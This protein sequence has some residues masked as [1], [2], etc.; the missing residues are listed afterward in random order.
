MLNPRQSKFL[1]G[2]RPWLGPPLFP[3]H[4]IDRVK[5]GWEWLLRTTKGQPVKDLKGRLTKGNQ[6]RSAVEEIL[7]ARGFVTVFGENAVTAYP[8]I[9]ASDKCAELRIRHSGGHFLVEATGLTSPEEDTFLTKAFEMGDFKEYHEWVNTHEDMGRF[10]EKIATRASERLITGPLVLCVSQYV[11]RP[12][13]S[14]G[15]E[16]LRDF[17]LQPG[18]YGVPSS[19]LLLAVAYST[20]YKANGIWFNKCVCERC[21]VTS[22]T[23]QKVAKALQEAYFP[24]ADDFF[25]C[26]I[27]SPLGADP[28]PS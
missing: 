21:G 28:N 18:C 23:A 15:R 9:G 1:D 22:E 13:P 20:C 24:R 6:M 17:L 12:D 16:R 19:I 5:E 3:P 27:I 2:L 7:L 14:E 26:C 8:K 4:S 11:S 10:C 25:E